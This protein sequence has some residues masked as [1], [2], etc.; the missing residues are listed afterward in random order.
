M[1]HEHWLVVVLGVR[2]GAERALADHFPSNLMSGKLS[3]E[4][5]LFWGSGAGK[6]L[7][8]PTAA[9]STAGAEV[10]SLLKNVYH[11]ERSTGEPV[12]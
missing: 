4:S 6:I 7:I 12:N 10:T 8:I 9:Y 2:R 11:F 1:H 5:I 3:T